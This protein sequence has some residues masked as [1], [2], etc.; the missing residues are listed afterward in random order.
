M[1]E[2]SSLLKIC[3]FIY[4]NINTYIYN[5]SKE[6]VSCVKTP[7][8]IHVM[9]WKLKH[10]IGPLDFSNLLIAKKTYERFIQ[11][12]NNFIVYY[13]LFVKRVVLQIEQ[14]VLFH[15]YNVHVHA[16]LNEQC[17]R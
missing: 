8:L 6:L 5:I 12:G 3:K 16:S 2:G 11:F 7:I 1:K 9:C 15:C 10:F 17:A 4:N 14:R 13:I